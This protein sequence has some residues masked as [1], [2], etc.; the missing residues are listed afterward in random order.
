MEKLGYIASWNIKGLATLENSLMVS[1]KSKN[2]FTWQPSNYTLEYLSQRNE[3][4]SSPRNL[5]INIHSRFIC[6]SQ[7]L[8][9][10]QMTFNGWLFKQIVISSYLLI[11][12]KEQTI[13]SCKNWDELQGNDAEWKTKKSQSQKIT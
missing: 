12:K 1:L 11:N 2:I 4:L 3:N 6:N 5:R 7:K 13:D 10:T 9:T 8:E